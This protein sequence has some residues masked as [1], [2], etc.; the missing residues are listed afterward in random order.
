MKN[1]PIFKFAIVFSKCACSVKTELNNTRGAMKCLYIKQRNKETIEQRAAER[2]T[3]SY[4]M[5]QVAEYSG[6][7]FHGYCM[8]LLFNKL[9]TTNIYTEDN[10][11][12]YANE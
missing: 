11:V 12:K 6:F 10:Y 1:K 7:T 5:L 9:I 8:F 2:L 4:L 3:I